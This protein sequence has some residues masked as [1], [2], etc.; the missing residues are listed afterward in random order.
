[1]RPKSMLISM[2]HLM[3]GNW[4]YNIRMD[5]QTNDNTIYRGRRDTDKHAIVIELYSCVTPISRP[6]SHV[7]PLRIVQLGDF[8]RNIVIGL[9]SGK[10][11]RIQM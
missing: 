7:Q 6:A 3:A 11:S 5:R 10:N 8:C 2:F 1:M 9:L 4:N